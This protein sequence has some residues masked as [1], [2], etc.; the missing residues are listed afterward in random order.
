MCGF[1][2]RRKEL[3]NLDAIYHSPG[4]RTC[5]VY[6][7]RRVG[8]TTLLKEFC[9]GKKSIFFVSAED[10]DANNARQF[11]DALSAFSGRDMSGSNTMME[12]MG[13]I[14]SICGRERIVLVIDEYPY[15]AASAGY[16]SSVLQKYI[17]TDLSESSIMLILCGSSISAM[18]DEIDGTKRPLFGRF[19]NRMEIGPLSYED[20]RGF[21]PG[22]SDKDCLELYMAAGGIPLYHTVMTD[23]TA[24][25]CIKKAF[26]G[27]YAPL[28]DEAMGMVMREL[29]PHG[30]HSAIL[31]AM[32]GGSTKKKEIAEKCGI[33]LQ[34]CT[35]YMDNMEFLG[36]IEP[37]EPMG[38]S[39]KRTI[40]R[41]KDYLLDFYYSVIVPDQSLIQSADPDAAYHRI[42]GNISTYMGK[43]FEKVCA[44]YMRSRYP[45][46]SVGR[47][48]GRIGDTDSDIDLVAVVTDGV[49]DASV[50]GECKYRSGKSGPEAL[51]KLIH[52]S[53]FAKGLLNRRYIIFSA[54]GFDDAL[55]ERA[56][57]TVFLISLDDL[58]SNEG[59]DL[60]G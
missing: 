5:A 16:M 18:K 32:A 33:S 8:K 1:I 35:K 52:R 38:G 15:L 20:C 17:D 27:T 9:K 51:D 22:M 19:L 34:L 13:K 25:E 28:R 50:F 36:M 39:P 4:F 23:D 3:A 60:F 30:V 12:A 57:G 56:S 29:S 47:W 59:P 37:V 45:C 44:E 6:G 54:A 26:M 21:H 24:E 10:T 31:S 14:K 11:D 42:S 43:A 2:G 46:R 55:K 40:Y 49:A 7:R 53:G 58:Y 41:I 48:W